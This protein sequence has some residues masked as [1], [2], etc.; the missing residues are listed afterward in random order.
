MTAQLEL[1]IHKTI[2][3]VEFSELN[4]VSNYLLKI[5]ELCFS[6][7]GNILSTYCDAEFLEQ[8]I[9]YQIWTYCTCS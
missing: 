7:K 4:L 5:L 1:L 9:Y 2:T 8:Y 3:C 6:A